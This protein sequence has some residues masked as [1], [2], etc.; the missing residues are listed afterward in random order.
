MSA[1]TFTTTTPAGPFTVLAAADHAVLASGW[2]DDPETLR[3]LV[4]PSLRPDRVVPGDGGDIA[5]AVREYLAGDLTATDR[6]AVRQ[7]SGAFLTHSWDVLRTV[8]AGDPVTYTRYAEL[9][10]RPAAV[11]AAANACARNAAALFVPCHRVLRTDGSLGGFRW[12][13][14]VKRWLLDHEAA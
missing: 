14:P 4:H 1:Y 7:A 13:L 9:S 10:G 6:I 12:G 11:R 2:T 3:V 8:P 5:A